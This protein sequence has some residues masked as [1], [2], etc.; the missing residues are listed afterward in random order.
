MTSTLQRLGFRAIAVALSLCVMMTACAE[1]S[2]ARPDDKKDLASSWVWWEAETPVSHNFPDANKSAYRKSTLDATPLSGG[3]WLSASPGGLKAYT[4]T[5]D[6]QVPET[7]TYTLWI[8]KFWHHTLFTWSFEDGPSGE[9]TRDAALV[10]DV[11]LRKFVGA[12]WVDAGRVKLEAG[13]HRFTFTQTI[14]DP[15]KGGAAFA[16]DCFALVP[17]AWS[18]RGKLR[19]GQ[20]SGLTE[21]GWTAFEPTVDLFTEE[22]LL[23]LRDRNHA[24]C[25]QKG[26]LTVR[27]G[28]FYWAEAPE[29]PV[30]FWG[31]VI[32]RGQIVATDQGQRQY[33]RR[34]AKLG[35]NMVRLHGKLHG[36][37]DDP[38]AIS[39]AFLERFDRFVATC[40]EN[41]VYFMV[42]TFY[43][44]WLRGSEVGGGYSD[45]GHPNGWQF[46]HPE[47]RALWRRWVKTL[48]DRRN[49]Y[50][51]MRNADDPTIAIVQI[52]NEDNYFFHTFQ[53]YRSIPVATMRYM[54][55][56]YARW[57]G[58]KY[59]SLEK[60][61][62]AWDG[63]DHKRDDPDAGRL[64]LMRVHALTGAGRRGRDQAAFMVHDYRSMTDG[65]IAHLRS[66]GY[67][68]LV[69]NGNWLSAD[70][71][72]LEPLDK[73]ANMNA[74]VMS[75]HGVL[76]GA[77]EQLEAFYA[78]R[79]GDSF[80][81]RSA[82]HE[83]WKLPL[84]ELHYNDRAHMVCE[85]KTTVP[86]RFRAEWPV[87]AACWGA[88]QGMDAQMHFAGSL[89]WLSKTQRWGIDEPVFMGQSPA[90][91]LLYR[92]GLVE[93]APV[94]IEETCDRQ[95]LLDL[96]GAAFHPLSSMSS[97]E[98]QPR[99]LALLRTGGDRGAGLNPLTLMT[100][101]LQRNIVDDPD[102]A[103]LEIDPRVEECI[104][105]KAKT[106]RSVDGQLTLDWGVGLL[107]IRSAKAQ[108]A[109]GFLKRAG[110]IDLPDMV[111]DLDNEY[112]SVICVPLDGKTLAESDRLLLTVVTETRNYGRT[113]EPTTFK[114]R[115]AP[116]PIDGRKITDVG[117]APILHRE[118]SGSVRLKHPD[119]D[120]L[121]VTA[122]NWNGYRVADCGSAD[123]IELRPDVISYVIH[124]RPSQ[125]DR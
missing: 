96:E 33:L 68:G 40:R 110:T 79:E 18:P 43:D 81:S 85:P 48:L 106:L 14:E 115:R 82:L 22:A 102:K 121:A 60:A 52:V 89:T 84:S 7:A 47:G 13:R 72:M 9:V 8:R 66:I 46:I 107:R 36:G 59:G 125:A 100:G 116:K 78:I 58:D 117:R 54:E 15:E 118:P 105:A 21:P 73:M 114:P 31:Q 45:R 35:V 69:N 25:G 12:N 23:D 86:N 38:L 37:A 19:P 92:E 34:M 97:G 1:E 99:D 17:F 20:T 51:G 53:P 49:P 122:V 77:D 104:D 6:V 91:S 63:P 90:L 3:D 55:K 41:G 61:K 75:R 2:T 109:V 67:D 120:E 95:A 30:R 124:R 57:L 56:R 94:V 88:L 87:L 76:W 103:G 101:S 113:T 98:I 50:T 10:D 44:H 11:R 111:I 26:R 119:A 24:V 112:A 5:Y 16:I 42:N 74:S 27:D 28:D 70:P 83:P 71:R 4:A 123:R 39:E 32:G 93:T 29:E 64:G 108:G 62:A 80:A 65:F